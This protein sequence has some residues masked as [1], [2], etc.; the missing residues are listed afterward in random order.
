MNLNKID[1]NLLVYLEVLLKERSVTNAAAQIGITQPALS[2]SLRRLRDL[3]DDPLLIRSSD[4]MIPTERAL[5]IQPELNE[6]LS[7]VQHL[8]QPVQ[9]FKPFT[10]QRIFR[11]MVSD[12][13]EATLMPTVVNNVRKEAPNVVL[14]LLT[15]SDVSF[16]DMEDGRVDM[17]INRFDDIPNAFHQKVLWTDDFACLMNKNNAIADRFNLK[18]Y[19]DSRHIWVSKTG[20]GAGKGVHPSK[21]S[22]LGWVDQALTRIGK[23]RDISVF[24]RHYQMPSLMTKNNDLVA[25]LPRRMAEL[26]IYAD[27]IVVMDPPFFIPSFELKMAW[28]PILQHNPAHRWLRKLIGYAADRIQIQDEKE[29]KV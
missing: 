27:D 29:R 6:V 28:S 4:G 1:L 5:R 11:I 25:T 24:T 2:N 26:Q 18:N 21:P 22:G 23:K 12:Y 7:K 8:V 14:D 15:P 3:F 19:L 13:A 16:S 9:A 20:W 10:S 17:A